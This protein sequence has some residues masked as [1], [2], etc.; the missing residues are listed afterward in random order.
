MKQ[1]LV[2]FGDSWTFGSELDRP[3]EQCWLAQLAK[4]KE[5]DFI[6]QSVPASS[7]GHLTVQLFDYIK[8]K[9]RAGYK[10]IFLVG[11]TGTSRHLTYSNLDNEFIN[12]TPEAV[13][14]T[15]NIDSMGSPP[16]VA[17]N[18]EP[19]SEWFYKTAEC[20]AYN[21]FV[22]NQ[23]VFAF[24]QYCRVSDIDCLF[25]SYFDRVQLDTTI[26][27][28]SFVYPTTITYALTGRE[29]SVP[30]VRNNQYFKDKLF[31]PNIDGHSCIAE[32]ISE[33]YDQQYTRN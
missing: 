11:L 6:N 19:L 2:G 33:F 28:T 29:Y 27:D 17:R 26:I 30:E 21:E 32:L 7:I 8:N 3:G 10:V 31:H 24:Q 5:A 15:R 25:F 9:Q 20:T 14:H 22:A 4:L 23:T 16:A 1:L 13:Y 18:M 12:I